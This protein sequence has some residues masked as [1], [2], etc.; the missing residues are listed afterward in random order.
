MRK[1]GIIII[2][3]LA[4]IMSSPILG[5]LQQ[6]EVFS[7]NVVTTS[8]NTITNPVTISPNKRS[9]YNDTWAQFT[10]AT[11]VLDGNVSEWIAE[12]IISENFGGA[13]IYLAYDATNAYVAVIWQDYWYD[14]DVSKWNKI[15][16]GDGFEMLAGADDICTVGFDDGADADYW[17]W[18][19]SN[20]TAVDYAYE[21]DGAGTPDAGTL[22]YIMNTNGT[23]FATPNAPF[24]DNTWDPIIDYSTIPLDTKITGWY[25]NEI[26]PTGSQAD[27]AVGWDYTGTHYVVEFQRAL[28]T[29]QVDDIVLDFTNNDLLF[30]IGVDNQNEAFNF[31]IATSS[32]IIFH[33]NTPAELAITS[34]I[35]A[36]VSES[37]LLIGSVFDDYDDYDVEIW[38]DEWTHTWGSPDTITVNKATG[39]WSYLLIFNE[40]DLPLGDINIFITIYPRYEEAIS[41]NQTTYVDDIEAPHIIGLTDIG[42][43][44]PTGVPIDEGY[45]TVTVGLNDDYSDVNDLLANIYWA[46]DDGIAL[47]TIMTQAYTD[48]STFF[49]DITIDPA[50]DYSI[51]HNYTYFIQAWDATGNKV[52]SMHFYFFTQTEVYTTPTNTTNIIPTTIISGIAF[53][54]ITYSFV[55]AIS[56]AVIVRLKKRRTN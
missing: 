27:V 35:P 33:E 4:S 53:G 41:V 39:S 8:L 32:N 15:D 12:G 16:A 48:S 52:T 40:M 51:Q 18:T 11:I 10:T 30:D 47:A 26:L 2:C 20:R 42:T 6:Q 24:W 21:H 13:E 46:K 19:A 54:S 9:Y 3:L 38:V 5:A 36:T 34:P 25:P 23:D 17:T 45:V 1:P 31:D 28:N 14:N 50:D 43:R 7:D 44:Y 55:L 22:P 29:G 49:A 56:I 37:L